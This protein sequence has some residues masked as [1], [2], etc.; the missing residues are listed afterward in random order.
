MDALER[1][2]SL[3]ARLHGLRADDEAGEGLRLEAA[4]LIDALVRDGAPLRTD[5]VDV[6]LLRPPMSSRRPR[7]LADRAV[8]GWDVARSRRAI[9]ASRQR[10]DGLLA[11][12]DA[13]SEV[14]EPYRRLGLVRHSPLT[15]PSIR[16]CV[17]AVR[18]ARAR[19]GGAKPRGVIAEGSIGAAAAAAAAAG[20]AVTVCEPNAFARRAIRAVCAA[21]GVGDLISISP[22]S[23]EAHAAC[24]ALTAEP[25]DILYLAPLIDDAGL[26][27][28]IL[29][30]AAAAAASRGRAPIT[31]PSRVTVWG[32]LAS[33]G[34]G[35]VEGVDLSALDAGR[36][37]PSPLPLA[38]EGEEG[39]RLLS[40]YERL[41]S[42]DLGSA[43]QDSAGMSR[44]DHAERD[45]DFAILDDL[46]PQFAD[47]A[48]TCHALVVG[49]GADLGPQSAELAEEFAEAP[50]RRAALFLE[51]FHVARGTTATLRVGHCATRVWA[52][53][54]EPSGE[55]LGEVSPAV[56][57]RWGRVLVQHWHYA[58]LRDDERN[59]AYAKA[60]RRAARRLVS[61][62][63]SADSA[64]H[65]PLAIDVGCGSGLL[66]LLL[67]KAVRAE[68][69]SRDE[70]P[71]SSPRVRCVGVEL[72]S[73]LTDLARRAIAENNEE[74]TV[75]VVRGDATR[76]CAE[77]G[78]FEPAQMLIAELM[79][80][81]GLGE[82]MLAHA[83]E[84]R[85]SG[86]LSPTAT[87]MPRRIRVWATLVEMRRL[88]N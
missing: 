86:L 21:H 64:N 35:R 28:R 38:V 87:L 79:D 17:A 48:S 75:T 58:M 59:G 40:R 77:A 52:T 73:G 2:A 84:A 53:P 14:L 83:A 16:A 22:R 36:W 55:S 76:L 74:D 27:K 56:A 20:A 33:L 70:R 51:P 82:S 41:F 88:P 54:P 65:A 50:H 24:G 45:V 6:I 71:H 7:V 9:C 66:S 67:A 72:L 23:L 18:R 85:A 43:I 30:A 47:G 11:W 49:V 34:A 25:A 26:G 57:E 44:W 1:L 81:G 68:E 42:F 19:S 62:N 60:L 13:R 69:K 3:Q 80:G 31:V 61:A 37:S 4:A 12:C 32:A 29:P 10:A 46:G 8:R 39:G 5:A 63:S 15:E 78:S